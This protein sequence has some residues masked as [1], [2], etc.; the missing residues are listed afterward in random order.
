MKISGTAFPDITK[1]EIIQIRDGKGEPID[2]TVTEC[3]N[4]GLKICVN[5]IIVR[6]RT[7]ILKVITDEISK[8]DDEK[9][10][11]WSS[12]MFKKVFEIDI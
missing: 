3:P 7:V 2:C 8:T 10:K 9:I 5:D 6:T 1:F 4:C 11:S 12:E